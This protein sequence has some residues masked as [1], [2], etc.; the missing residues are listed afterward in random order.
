VTVVIPMRNEASCIAGCLESILASELPADITIEVLVLDGQSTDDSP[1]IVAGMALRD[2]R[3]RLLPNPARLQA[4]AFNQGLATARGQYLVRM[5]AHSVYAPDYIAECLRLL[6]STGAGNVGGVQQATGSSWLT[7]AIAAAVSSRFAAGDAQYR[8]ATAPGFTDTV[9]LGAWR[10]ATLH[11]LGGMRTDWAVNEDYEMN[12]RLRASGG[13]V[14][15]SPTIRSTYQVRSSAMRLARQ[16]ARYGF[17]KV[18]TLLEHPASLRWRQ[19]VA[20]AFVVSILLTPWLVSRFGIWGASH[21]VL[22]AAAN[23]AA[24]VIVA[25]RAGMALL[26][27]LPLV[28][29][30]IHCSWGA[31]FLTGLAWWPFRRA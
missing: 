28:F 30:I 20:P 19:L 23:A 21:L 29:F 22:Y 12:V 15:L 18:R 6:E 4:A 24:S 27:V 14:Y 11:E 31:G 8:N 25:R 2:A 16:Y 7:R 13:T 9:Y 17:W 10:T 5:D 26:P 3:I 1:A